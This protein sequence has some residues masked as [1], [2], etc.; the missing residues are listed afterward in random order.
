[1][2]IDCR[3]IFCDRGLR[4]TRQRNAIFQALAKSEA[5]PTADQLHELVSS[6]PNCAGISLAT[7]YNTLDV[8]C[9]AR[10][11]MKLPV[12]QGSAR[13]DANQICRTHENGTVDLKYE[14]EQE[15]HLHI[16]DQESGAI[17]DVSSVLSRRIFAA[18]PAKVVADIEAEL[19]Y[20]IHEIAL[21]L[22]GSRRLEN[23]C[24]YAIS[25][26]P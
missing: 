25:H 9:E 15:P 17:I 20:D 13:Y 23:S 5:H 8:L 12:T 3:Q 10:L 16:V 11:C 26:S 1:M 21:Q 2:G 6:D 24:D 18:I 22:H 19:G 7:V 4:F 14:K